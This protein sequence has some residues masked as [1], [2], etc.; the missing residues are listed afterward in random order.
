MAPSS[1]RIPGS[2]AVAPVCLNGGSRRCWKLPNTKH[3]GAPPGTLGE[4]LA[5]CS[6]ATGSLGV[7][8]DDLRAPGP[9][10]RETAGI[11]NGCDPGSS[12][13]RISGGRLD[14]VD[15]V[16]NFS[17]STRRGGRYNA[18]KGSGPHGELLAED[19]GAT[20]TR[21]FV[22]T[23]SGNRDMVFTG[24]QASPTGATT[25]RRAGGYLAEGDIGLAPW[26]IPPTP[27][28]V[29]DAGKLPRGAAPTANS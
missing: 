10:L 11:T 27:R 22:K 3:R 29:G 18:P 15:A 24:R 19:S 4:L 6:V 12:C 5:G 13:G 8:D 28:A 9:E 17:N 7:H 1:V 20:E 16:G 26:R 14:W 25:D 2:V 23:I 21:G